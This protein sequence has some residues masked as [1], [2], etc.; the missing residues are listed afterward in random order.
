MCRSRRRT[1]FIGAMNISR[2]VADRRKGQG[3]GSHRRER[4][5]RGFDRATQGL[6]QAAVPGTNRFRVAHRGF[7]RGPIQSDAFLER[8]S[9]GR[10]DDGCHSVH[11]GLSSREGY[12]LRRSV[13]QAP[14]GQCPES[15]SARLS[16]IGRFGIVKSWCLLWRDA[17]VCIL[18]CGFCRQGCEIDIG[19][20][21]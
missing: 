6:S 13:T 17:A 4:V 15:F 20:K 21:A 8:L 12:L 14:P 3:D 5:G 16:L 1:S 9:E 19:L 11:S 2:H 18:G 10:G 7:E